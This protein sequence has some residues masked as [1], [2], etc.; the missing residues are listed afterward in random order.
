MT[1]NPI[2]YLD[3]LAVL[4]GSTDVMT[5]EAVVDLEILLELFE[6]DLGNKTLRE[7]VRK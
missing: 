7:F 3:V 4:A 5:R 2:S 6:T 1:W